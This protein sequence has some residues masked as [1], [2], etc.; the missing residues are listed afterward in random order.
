L[1]L[2]LPGMDG[3]DAAHRIRRHPA[4]CFIPILAVTGRSPSDEK[5][6]RLQDGCEDYIYNPF[7]PSLLVTRIERLME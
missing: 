1:D 5:K 7:P 2:M 3:L 4:T 6:R